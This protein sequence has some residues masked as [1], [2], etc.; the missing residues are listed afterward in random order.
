MTIFLVIRAKYFFISHN[1]KD[2]FPVIPKRG[3]II[4]LWHGT[5]IKKIGLDSKIEREWINDLIRTGRNLP[6]ER[7]NYF[8]SA[9]DFTSS[10]FKS[11]MKLPSSKIKPLG[12]PRTDSLYQASIDEKVKTEIEEGLRIS[13]LLK[14]KKKILYAPTFRNKASSDLVI[15]DT[16]KEIDNAIGENSSIVFL[17]KPHP[18]NKIRFQDDILSK[19]NNIIDVSDE[20][21][22][23]LLC[24]V[25]LLITDYS[26]IMFDFMITRKPIISYIFDIEQYLI[27]NGELYFSFR[28]LGTIVVDNPDELVSSIFNLDSLLVD[29]DVLKFN[30][31]FSCN[32]IDNF[33][34][35]L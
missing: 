2:I 35:E 10:I 24:V 22:Q 9:T 13:G 17:F 27:E 16:L 20:D 15:I 14:G 12:Q 26:S 1:I 8:I 11:A 25:D 34:K 5:P 31:V 32:E 3:V 21:T 19:W 4:N 6:Y 7:W 18:L 28:E 30:T 33:I 29:Y 23:E